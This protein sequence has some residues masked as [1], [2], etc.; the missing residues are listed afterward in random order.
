MG[1]RVDTSRKA[2]LRF[3]VDAE[4][5]DE[6]EFNRLKEWINAN[7]STTDRRTPKWTES[8]WGWEVELKK[9]RF[10]FRFEEDAMAFKLILNNYDE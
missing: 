9:M 10:S 6:E 8:E 1:R 2:T 5:P 7:V 4:V 3:W